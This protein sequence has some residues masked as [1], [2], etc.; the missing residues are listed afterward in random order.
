MKWL[1]EAF[2]GAVQALERACFGQSSFRLP[3]SEFATAASI[4]NS[5]QAKMALS[6]VRKR[7]EED[8]QV[9]LGWP[10]LVELKAPPAR[11]WK[12][13]F[14]NAEGNL[15]RHEVVDFR[16]QPAHQMWIRPGLVRLRFKSLL[17]HELVHA[18]QREA[19]FLTQ[20]LGLREGMARWVEYHFLQ[21][22]QEA[23]RLLTVKHYTFGKAVQDIILHE[24][25]AGR[26]ATLEWLRKHP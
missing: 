4:D 14:Y 22:T 18:Y 3:S 9:R 1:G 6:E 12:A 19:N 26:A 24:N 11:G 13:Q 10:I 8:F 2:V 7:L 21:G 5:V 15:A 16:G 25:K 20:N 17:A 23:N